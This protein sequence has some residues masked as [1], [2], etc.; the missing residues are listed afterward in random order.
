MT[1][2]ERTSQGIEELQPLTVLEQLE[3]A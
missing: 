2:A 3:L 1:D